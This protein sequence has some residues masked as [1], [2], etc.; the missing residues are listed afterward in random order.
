MTK[1]PVFGAIIND[2]EEWAEREAILSEDPNDAWLNLGGVWWP[3][4][5]YCGDDVKH[6]EL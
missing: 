1:D 5:L 6:P 2:Y 3:N 4:P